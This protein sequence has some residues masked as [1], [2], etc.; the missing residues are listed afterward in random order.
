[1]KQWI[2]R[3]IFGPTFAYNYLLG[4]VFKVRAWWNRIDPHVILGA[5]P[6]ARDAAALKAEGVTGVVNMCEEYR[7]PLQRYQELGIEQLWLPTV[8][9][10]HPTE[11]FVNAGAEF[12]ERHAQRGG[13]VYVHCKAG[14]ARSATIVLWWLVRFGRMSPL[15][16]QRYL[17]EKRPHINPKVYLRPVIQNLYSK[18]A[19]TT[20]NAAG[21]ARSSRPPADE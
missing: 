21:S 16:A 8:D 14:R 2:A 17:L 1:M 4:R 9:F 15:E 6:L 19:S 18:L 11:E 20:N 10:T 12:I 13:T 7:G 5:L 3:S